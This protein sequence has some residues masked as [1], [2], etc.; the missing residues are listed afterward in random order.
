M[1]AN[2][3]D[4]NKIFPKNTGKT[5]NSF[6]DNNI[7]RQNPSQNF[8]EEEPVLMNNANLVVNQFKKKVR[9]SLKN[10]RIDLYRKSVKEQERFVLT[11][12]FILSEE[13]K[14][15]DYSF[16]GNSVKV[17]NFKITIE[18]DLLYELLNSL[19]QKHRDIIYL[20]FCENWTDLKISDK[21]DMTRSNVQR[22][23]QKI[24]NEIYNALK[25]KVED[26]D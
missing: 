6:R 14:C 1:K 18:N 7:E 5:G 9:E 17:L 21:L 8:F 2:K 19:E 26:S 24:K 20:S 22:I 13:G 15:D 3:N 16:L 11:E 25:G 4:K 12:D 23:K 10:H